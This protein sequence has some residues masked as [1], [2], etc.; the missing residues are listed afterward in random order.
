M[1]VQS[2]EGR[3]S[4][5]DREWGFAAPSNDTT[6]ISLDTKTMPSD[7]TSS[8]DRTSSTQTPFTYEQYQ[9]AQASRGTSRRQRSTRTGGSE[10]TSQASHPPSDTKNRTRISFPGGRR[11]PDLRL[12][13]N[14]EECGQCYVLNCEFS[15]SVE[16]QRERERRYVAR[17]RAQERERKQDMVAAPKDVVAANGEPDTLDL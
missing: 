4:S 5:R 2:T 10:R 1:Y 3:V 12:C 14:V 6:S 17:A 7:G 15:H 9:K 16:E 11:P 8:V 13:R